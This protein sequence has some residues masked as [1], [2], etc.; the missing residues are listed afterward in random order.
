MSYCNV[1]FRCIAQDAT[2][3]SDK[4]F[5]ALCPADGWLTV[6][7]R[8]SFDLLCRSVRAREAF[9]LLAPFIAEAAERFPQDVPWAFL[10]HI[11]EGEGT[12]KGRIDL[13]GPACLMLRL[14]VSPHLHSLS[15]S[16]S[17]MTM[18]W[19]I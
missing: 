1:P 6:E 2:V 9:F 8:K 15:R 5:I 7:S 18:N 17:S 3:L 14:W 12:R 19:H 4:F 11:K 16:I 13:G 10:A